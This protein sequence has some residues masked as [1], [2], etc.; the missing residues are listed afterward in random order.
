[1]TMQEHTHNKLLYCW[2][3]GGRWLARETP[4]HYMLS[5]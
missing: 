5:S 3:K 1:M 4:L 2:F